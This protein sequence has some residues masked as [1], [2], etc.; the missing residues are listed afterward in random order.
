MKIVIKSI[1]SINSKL[2]TGAKTCR[3]VVGFVGFVGL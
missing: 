2:K 1:L 3:K